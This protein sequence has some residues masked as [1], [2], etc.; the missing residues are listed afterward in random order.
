MEYL[1]PIHLS[2]IS[3]LYAFIIYFCI[4]LVAQSQPE[5]CFRFARAALLFFFICSAL[6]AVV[7]PSVVI[8]T[9]YVGGMLGF[10]FRYYGLATHANT[11]GPLALV[12]MICLWRFPFH[13]RWVNLFSWFLVT[14]SLVLTQSKTTIICRFSNRAFPGD[15]PLSSRWLRD[16]SWRAF[17]PF[18]RHHSL[19]LL[20]SFHRYSLELARI[21]C[22]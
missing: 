3:V 8:Q 21:G 12:F 18:Y 4:F 10:P 7:I 19:R 20:F 1:A 16:H 5:R 22:G 17:R 9:G 14:T 11:M 6:A 15:L 13:S 2:I